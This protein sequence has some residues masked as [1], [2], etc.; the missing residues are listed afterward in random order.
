V[1]FGSIHTKPVVEGLY[2]LSFSFYKKQQLNVFLC[3]TEEEKNHK[4]LENM[5]VSI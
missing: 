2:M 4:G 1:V 5:R 3:S